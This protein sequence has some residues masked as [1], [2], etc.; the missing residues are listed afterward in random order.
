[1]VALFAFLSYL[2]RPL[3]YYRPRWTKPF[4]IESFEQQ[5]DFLLKSKKDHWLALLIILLASV[6]GLTLQTIT[7]CLFQWHFASHF[8]CVSWVRLSPNLSQPCLFGSGHWDLF[9]HYR[10]AKICSFGTPNVISEHCGFQVHGDYRPAASDSAAEYTGD[11]KFNLSSYHCYFH[12]YDA[13]ER[14]SPV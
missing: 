5:D 1:M 10:S 14:L 6:A 4:I 7:S 8:L 11:P 12:P 3:F 9:V 2:F 13:I